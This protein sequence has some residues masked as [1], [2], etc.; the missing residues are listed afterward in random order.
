[1]YLH[2]VRVQGVHELSAPP[3]HLRFLG[4]VGPRDL[5]HGIQNP[6]NYE[7]IVEIFGLNP[8]QI[9]LNGFFFVGVYPQPLGPKMVTLGHFQLFFLP[10]ECLDRHGAG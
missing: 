5:C 9:H 6:H 8:C 7:K 1:M 2:R 10:T 4:G 3:P